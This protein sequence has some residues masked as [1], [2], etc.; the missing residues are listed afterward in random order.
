MDEE[1]VEESFVSRHV[2]MDAA[3]KEATVKCDLGKLR[4]LGIY[5]YVFEEVDKD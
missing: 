2:V 1:Q 5:L 3:M 4:Q